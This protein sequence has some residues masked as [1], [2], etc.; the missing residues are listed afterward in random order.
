MKIHKPSL[1]KANTQCQSIVEQGRLF[2]IHVD[3]P[4]S[5]SSVFLGFYIE[6]EVPGP[7]R[8]EEI[9]K[10]SNSGQYLLSRTHGDGKR[11]FD[12]EKRVVD[13]EKKAKVDFNP[14]PGS[15]RSPS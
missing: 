6:N 9:N 2:L 10:L 11:L 12:H 4:A 15:Y 5:F 13:F 14:G 3:L 1:R 7:G 8:Y